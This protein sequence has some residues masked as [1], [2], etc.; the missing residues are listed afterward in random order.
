ME[1]ALI[2]ALCLAIVLLATLPAFLDQ[3][4][5]DRER[6]ESETFPRSPV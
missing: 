2:A 5:P 3:R 4:F 1:L 6:S